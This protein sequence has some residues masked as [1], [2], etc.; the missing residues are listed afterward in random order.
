[1][2]LVIDNTKNQRLI[3]EFYF[4]EAG[5]KW[6]LTI[7]PF[8]LNEWL[9]ERGYAQL[10]VS[11]KPRVEQL[12]QLEDGIIREVTTKQVKQKIITLIRNRKVEPEE[13]SIRRKCLDLLMKLPEKTLQGY[14]ANLV[15]YA[16]EP[17]VDETRLRV[18]RD[19]KNACFL[20][21]KNG[22]VEI[23]SKSVSLIPYSKNIFDKG[24]IYESS[25]IDRDVNIPD[26][27]N[28]E[29]DGLVKDQVGGLFADFVNLAFKIGIEPSR[30]DNDRLLGTDND[31]YVATVQE[32]ERCY[33]YLLHRY[34]DPAAARA[35]VF[36]DAQSKKGNVAGGTGKSVIT[37]SIEH[38]RNLDP[39]DGRRFLGSKSEGARFN[40][41]T[42][43]NATEVALIND[44]KE[45][46][47][48]GDIFNVITDDMEVEGKGAARNKFVI[49]FERKP[50]IV[51]TTNYAVGGTGSSHERRKVI[52]RI[53]DFF[54]RCVAKK[55]TPPDILGK[56]LFKDFSVDEWNAYDLYAMGC[57]QQFLRFGIGN[58]TNKCNDR[59]LLVEYVEGLEGT[60]CVVDFFDGF[61]ETELSVEG[62]P[63][64]DLWKKFSHKVLFKDRLGRC[65][66]KTKLKQML[67]RYCEKSGITFNPHKT[68]NTVS[69]RRWL[70]GPRGAQVEWIKLSKK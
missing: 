61:V 10:L 70:S 7:S 13:K 57:I 43:T 55:I 67:W 34:N 23:T 49:P 48:L 12:I 65:D 29:K 39:I 2:K 53:G 4:I 18:F 52:I 9:E 66:D 63:I 24:N 15:V 3:E 69:D 36:I 62:L 1:M 20:P 58:T 14:L 22:V 45:D 32:F 38:I 16:E 6:K 40:F 51:L 44:L 54:S 5:S 59:K 8:S 47:D 19:T 17:S 27:M 42:I 56:T 46:F 50:K 31:E 33:G 64:D 41:S 25:I 26:G 60:G 21:Y 28:V 37:K 68:G 30:T 35:I 11:K